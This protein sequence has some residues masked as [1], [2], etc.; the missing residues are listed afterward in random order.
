[1]QLNSKQ[2]AYLR[3]LAHTL[4]PVVM[5][6]NNGLTD[7][8]LKEIDVSLNA[9]ELIKVQVAGDDR[10]LRKALLTDIADKTN[11]II[12]HHIGKQLVFYRASETV[13]ASAK[14]VIPKL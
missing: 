1:M 13:K 12:V 5:I 6:G 14:I 4:N 10:E 11:A 9:H 7:A 3:G 2:I 8:V